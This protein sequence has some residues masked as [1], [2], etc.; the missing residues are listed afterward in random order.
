[1]KILKTLLSFAIFC[2]ASTYS[3]TIGLKALI[4]HTQ[5][6]ES[7][8]SISYGLESYGISYDTFIINNTENVLTGNLP[9]YDE[10]GNPK[11][12]LIIL[13]SGKLS[14]VTEDGNTATSL[15]DQ[16]W[17]Y[18][19]AYEQ[20]YKIRRVTF[21]DTP[22]AITGTAIYDAVNWGNTYIQKMV[23]ADNAIADDIYGKAGVKKDAPIAT[24]NNFYHTPVTITNSNIATPIFY[25]EP[26]DELQERTVGA[27]YAKLE[28]GRERLNFYIP[29][30]SWSLD[31]I[32]LNHLWIQWG[33][34]TIYNGIR[35]I[36][37]TPHIDDFFISTNCVDIT[38]PD[39]CAIEEQTEEFR[40][41]QSDIE[42]FIAFKKN[43]TEK[44]PEGSSFTVDLA[45]NGNGLLPDSDQLQVDGERYVEIDF[46][47][48]M[49]E[50]VTN[51][52][53]NRFE[54]NWTEEYLSR[55]K[56]YQYFKVKENRANFFW[57]SHTFTHENLDNASRSDI[58]NE[59]RVNIEMAKMLDLVDE[60]W[61]SSK[62]II[63]P[64]I[65]GLHNGDAIEIFRQYGIV[66]A[67]GDISRDDITNSTNPYLPFITTVDTSSVGGF[68]IIPRSPTEI[69]YYASTPEENTY[70]YN[71]MYSSYFG[72][73]STWEQILERE[74]V[75]VLRLMML[76]RHEAHQFHQANM[77]S[78]DSTDH[79]S[80]LQ[81]W[82]EAVI[83]LYNKYVEWPLVSY[84]LDD[85]NQL[86]IDRLNTQLCNASYKL[87]V[88][89]G[90]LTE[91]IVSTPP[92]SKCILPLTV[93]EDV[94]R[95]PEFNYEQLGNDP[96]TVWINIDANVEVVTLDPPLL[97]DSSSI[98]TTTTITTTTIESPTPT[99]SIYRE[100]YKEFFNTDWYN[101]SNQNYVCK[102]LNSNKCYESVNS[103]WTK[104]P[105]PESGT[106]CDEMNTICSKI[107]TIVKEEE[108]NKFEEFFT[109][110][111][112]SCSPGDWACKTTMSDEC[113]AKS[114]ECW[115]QPWS[116]GVDEIC[117]KMNAVCA[118]IWV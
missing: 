8:Q 37:F 73:D 20:T 56:L 74:S 66:S 80:L 61:W 47:K 33:T 40:I 2:I 57:S 94:V 72:G 90:Y 9:L 21:S 102:Q 50:G 30:A 86:S 15:N 42:D 93:P 11:Y 5:N 65:S 114:S 54:P 64:Q 53:V 101:C 99:G 17:A 112:T 26:C 82:V 55:D 1:M 36:S 106:L 78:D 59:I 62:S 92:N 97:W 116:P 22:E 111:W 34:R 115:S 95:K 38:T 89:D 58:D 41:S 71:Y 68:P 110:N 118:S 109:Q 88:E 46:I 98:P 51:W 81:D 6:D 83:N 12:Y 25:F 60:E 16:Q 107:W 27:V 113:Y 49:G 39:E 31:A 43:I 10:E 19:D 103:C 4:L 87:N 91:I 76:L 29:T 32:V 13:T 105:W 100:W 14:S 79:H 85:L 67:T 75:R 18:L 24:N 3:Y 69:Y 63:T 45:F 70:I 108:I 7:F 84:K 96:L 52:P 77:R 23:G 28:D 44:M 104:V 48:P 117:N 35:R